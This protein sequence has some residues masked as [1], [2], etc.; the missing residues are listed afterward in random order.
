MLGIL[1]FYMRYVS[2][3]GILIKKNKKGNEQT[4]ENEATKEKTDKK[5]KEKKIKPS[6]YCL[7][8]AV[9]FPLLSHKFPLLLHLKIQ[10]RIVI[11]LHLRTPK[12]K[13]T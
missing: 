13:R 12:R 2:P 3:Y 8:K 10:S 1:Y 6:L 11:I 9:P 4:K 5:E 7:A